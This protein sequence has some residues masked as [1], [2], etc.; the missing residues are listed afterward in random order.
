MGTF[1]LQNT[2]LCLFRRTFCANSKNSSQ[3]HDAFGYSI[4]YD[5]L[6][7]LHYSLCNLISPYSKYSNAEADG[8]RKGRQKR[9][10]I[11]V[12]VE[13]NQSFDISSGLTEPHCRLAIECKRWDYENKYLGEKKT[14]KKTREMYIKRMERN[15][16]AFRLKSGA[17]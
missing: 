3:S 17:R 16:F 15:V 1:V 13:N 8:W 7:F 10:S 9:E 11:S 4:R 2:N 12:S 5:V 6:I 14:K